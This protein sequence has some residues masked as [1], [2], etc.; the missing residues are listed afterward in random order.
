MLKTALDLSRAVFAYKNGCAVWRTHSIY[1]FCL[2]ALKK[3]EASK[4]FSP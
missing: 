1:G 3:S 4:N 2:V